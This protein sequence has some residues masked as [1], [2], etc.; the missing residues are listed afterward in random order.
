MPLS[1]FEIDAEL[2]QPLELPYFE[3]DVA[4]RVALKLDFSKLDKS[5]LL[6][7]DSIY[8]RVEGIP[9]MYPTYDPLAPD[10][11]LRGITTNQ[12]LQLLWRGIITFSDLNRPFV[13]VPSY[14]VP[15]VSTLP[16]PLD[17]NLLQAITVKAVRAPDPTHFVNY[18]VELKSDSTGVNRAYVNGYTFGTTGTAS[19][20]LL[21]QYLSPQGGPDMIPIIK[22]G[23]IQGSGET[24]FVLPYL[25][26]VDIFINNTDGGA[27]PFHFHGHSFWVIST[28]DYPTAETLYRDNYMFRDVVSVPASGKTKIFK[29]VLLY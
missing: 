26:V 16:P 13:G 19:A 6:N 4:Q 14:S 11:G 18:L 12:P 10:L 22:N 17:T 27:H 9:Q 23:F 7:S 8:F 25:S 29:K 20:P 5:L 1:V 2:V 21:H 24:P 28:S 15:P 3:I